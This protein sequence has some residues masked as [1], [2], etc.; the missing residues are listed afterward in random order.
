VITSI[1][2]S[3]FRGIRE[4]KLEGLTPL[5]V[6]VG[7]NGCGKSNVL[8][9]LLLVT[10]PNTQKA[11]QEVIQRHKGVR[12]GGRWFVW[13]A[14]PNGNPSVAVASARPKKPLPLGFW[15]D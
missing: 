4:G 2:I 15:G 11:A 8:D 12:G 5:T 13:R 10:S 14:D 1:E 3:R 6:L 7:A 9:A